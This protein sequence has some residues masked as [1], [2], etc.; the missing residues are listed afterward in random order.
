LALVSPLDKAKAADATN[1]AAKAEAAHQDIAGIYT[2]VSVNGKDVPA[3]L[4]HEGATLEVRSGSFEITADGKCVSKM[5][6][7]PPSHKEVTNYTYATY[8]RKDQQLKMR[9]KG[10]GMTLGVVEGKTFT[11]TNEDMVLTYRLPK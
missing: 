2:L 5:I 6:F 9:W 4:N 11:M 8:T 3:A 1:T 10:A 7:L